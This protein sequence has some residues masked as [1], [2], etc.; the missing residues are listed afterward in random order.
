MLG[1]GYRE[2]SPSPCCA[3]A[4]PSA[5]SSCTPGR[6]RPFTD[7]QIALLQTF[8]DQ[9][10][11]AIENV[12]LFKELET[13]NRDLTETLEQ[14]TATGEILRVIS[15]SPTDV[16]PVFDTIARERGAALR[17]HSRRL[18]VRRRAAPL[19]GPPWATPERASMPCGSIFRCPDRGTAAGRAVLAPPSCTFRTCDADPDYAL[20]SRGEVASASAACVAVPMVRD[21]FPSGRSPS[22]DPGP[23]LFPDRQIDLLKTFADQAVIAIENVR[24]FKELEVRNR[25]LTEALEQQTATGEILR[26]ISSSPTDVQPVLDTVAESAARLCESFDAAIWRRDGDGS[27]S[28]PI[29]VRSPIGRHRESFPSRS[30]AGPSLADRCW[31]GGPSTSQT[32]RREVGR[33]PG[34][35]ARTRGAW[36]SARSSASR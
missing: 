13:R 26:V 20:G 10:V 22:C 1:A 24:L 34:D 30:S 36:A 21:G 15:S 6:T 12:R 27:S 7:K 23:G 11:I 18:S 3:V 4:R 31:T 25:D 5:P 19:R 33:I 16:Q 29:T 35:A 32:R 9:A 2:S 8:A 28:S 17:G 14:Q